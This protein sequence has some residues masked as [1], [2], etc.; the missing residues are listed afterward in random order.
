[1]PDAT[2]TTNATNHR[3]KLAAIVY[4]VG[5]A[6]LFDCTGHT[7]PL[8]RLA[9]ADYGT[10]ESMARG[11]IMAG[12]S[13]LTYHSDTAGDVSAVDWHPGPGDLW[14]EFKRPPAGSR[15]ALETAKAGEP[16]QA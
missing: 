7:R 13:V 4:Q 12:A 6:N 14:A 5:I 8:A 15:P 11:L 9:Q 3:V 2:T 16:R 1:M 10:I